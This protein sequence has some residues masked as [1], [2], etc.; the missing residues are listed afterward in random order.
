MKTTHCYHCG[1]SCDETIIQKDDKFFC[2]NGCKT[3]YEIFSE[4]DLTCYYDFQENP[5]AI[6]VEIQ[7]K[8]DFLE[9]KEIIEKLLDFND[10]N[11]QIATFYIPHIH[12]SSCIW[13]LENLHKLNSK[14]STSQVD[15]P[16]KT[17]RITFNLEVVSLKEIVLL[18][19]S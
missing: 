12:C 1:D 10:G 8:Y 2:C 18:L 19:S 16:K 3:V 17:V 4:N 7:G 14:I 5:G 9:N 13:V 11:T 15:F 6:P